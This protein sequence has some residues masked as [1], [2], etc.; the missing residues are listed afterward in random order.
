MKN[1]A[2][3]LTVFSTLSLAAC[4]WFGPSA[5]TEADGAMMENTDDSMMQNDDAMMQRSSSDAM[6]NDDGTMKKGDYAAYSDAVLADGETKV[7]FFAASWCPICKIADEKLTTWYSTATP[8]YSVYKVDYDAS[9]A[10][11]AEYGVTY[12]HT[13]VLVDGEGKMVRKIQGPTDDELKEL[14]GA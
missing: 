6:M 2:L 11:K 13:F 7:L 9:S 14:I 1:Y 12:Q 8:G 3:L 5:D 10:L 4:D